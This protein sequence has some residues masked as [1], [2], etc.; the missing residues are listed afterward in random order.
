MLS[1]WEKRENNFYSGLGTEE[2]KTKDID[3][4]VESEGNMGALKSLGSGGREGGEKFELIEPMSHEEAK[5]L[6]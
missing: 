3:F 2:T 4:N 5:S 6:C 1:P